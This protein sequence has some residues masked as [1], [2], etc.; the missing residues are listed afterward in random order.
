MG[1]G[2]GEEAMGEEGRGREGRVKVG[3]LPVDAC[4]TKFREIESATIN[5]A[6]TSVTTSIY[7]VPDAFSRLVDPHSSKC[8]V[9]PPHGVPF[10]R[11][12][13][14]FG[15]VMGAVVPAAKF[16]QLWLAK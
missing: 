14:G 16:S 8:A 13:Q 1:G 4:S 15:I 10:H 3:F 5:P 11:A 12:E 7:S 6:G 2:K 9:D